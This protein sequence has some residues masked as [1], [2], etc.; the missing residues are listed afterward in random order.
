MSSLF[1]KNIEPQLKAMLAQKSMGDVVRGL[2]SKA[3]IVK[4]DLNGEEI[5]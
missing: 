5:K 4:Y 3:K 1:L 2:H